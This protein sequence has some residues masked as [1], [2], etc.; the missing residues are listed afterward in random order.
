MQRRVISNPFQEI[1]DIRKKDCRS[2]TILAVELVGFSPMPD[3]PE[4]AE[5]QALLVICLS[6]TPTPSTLRLALPAVTRFHGRTV[7][8]LQHRVGS[9]RAAIIAR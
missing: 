1:L 6:E 2:C 9:G 8:P 3:F 7:A 4:I 5:A